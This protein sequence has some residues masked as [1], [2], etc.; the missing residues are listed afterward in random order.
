MDTKYVIRKFS[1]S[2]RCRYFTS[3]FS[4]QADFWEFRIT[5]CIYD[6]ADFW[7]ISFYILHIHLIFHVTFIFRFHIYILHMYFNQQGLVFFWERRL[8]DPGDLRRNLV[9]HQRVDKEWESCGIPPVSVWVWE[10]WVWESCSVWVWESCGIPPVSVW[11]WE[12]WV[13]ESCSVWVWESC[14]IPP[15]GIHACMHAYIHTHT[16]T[17]IQTH[18]CIHTHAYTRMHTH[19]CIHIHHIHITCI[20]THHV[21]INYIH[22]HKL[23]VYI[24]THLHITYIHAH[25]LHTL[26]TYT[27]CIP[28]THYMHTYSTSHT[29]YIHTYT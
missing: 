3:Q 20:H 15:V 13:W 21:H 27:R 2:Q 22:T 19:A 8:W 18:A 10:S 29:H 16:E 23:H 14:G 5:Y 28:Y 9:F 4:V 25:T 17:R 1:K 6:S 12:S 7:R 24:H 26:H 11:L